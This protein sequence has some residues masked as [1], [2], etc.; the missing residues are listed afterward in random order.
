MQING[1]SGINGAQ[2]LNGPQ[3]LNR[4]Q[5]TA[6]QKAAEPMHGADQLDISHEAQM[7]SRAN[8]A[9]GDFRADLVASIRSQIQAGTYDTPE[10]LDIAVGRLFDRLG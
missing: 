10:K 6:A 1:P 8:E 3:R 7:A 2:S 9:T 5:S 4:T